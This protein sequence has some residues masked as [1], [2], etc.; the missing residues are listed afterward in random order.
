MAT[1]AAALSYKHA[2]QHLPRWE[3]WLLRHK[4]I[5]EIVGGVLVVVSLVSVIWQLTYPTNTALPAM[6]LGGIEVG[7]KDRAA[8][9]ATLTDYAQQGEV[10][11]ASPSRQWQAKWQSVGVNIDAEAS[12]DVALGYE[13]W[14]RFIPFSSLIRRRQ[15]QDLQLIALVDDERLTEFASKLVAEDKQAARDATIKVQDGAVVIDDAKNGYVYDLQEVKQQV[16]AAAVST[17][18]TLRLTPQQTAYVRSGQELAQVKAQAETVLAHRPTFK[19]GNA[20]FTADAPTVGSWITFTEDPKTKALQMGFNRDQ[21]KT[22]LN[23]IDDKTK[24][25][26]GTSTVTL[27][28]GQEVSRTPAPSGQTVAADASLD[29]IQAALLGA[30][31]TPTVALNITNVPPKVTY[32]RN[33][34]QTNAGLLA[35]IKDW[36]ATHYG[37]YAVIIRELGGQNR[38]AEFNPDKQYVTASTFKLWVY[39]A[40]Q[41]RI[42]KGQ[43]SY[44]TVTDMGWTVEACLQEMIVRSTNPCA[45]SL[46]N[47][48]GWQESQNLVAAAGFSS[49]NINNFAG[50][51]KTSTIRDETNFM[52]RLYYG[53]LMGPEANDRL[54]GYLKRQIWRT[55]IPVG[56]PRGTVV[57]NKVGLYNGWVHDVG[58]IYGPK[59]TFIIGIM[60]KSGTDP[61]FAELTR[62]VYNFFLN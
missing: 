28:D 12:V 55:G 13:F 54:L 57:A 51:D 53:T 30:E 29:K 45:A 62:R 2:H 36:D 38:Y 14:E 9:V 59:S 19:V 22:Y 50:G 49:T 25:A 60:S 52:M 10:T 58:I 8:L 4:R 6:K 23:E 33:Y 16:Q 47:L 35:I 7:G 40:V 11:I 44:Q 61:A 39:Y 17:N 32:V 3:E 31:L 37:D 21:I 18:A 1:K 46:M 34:S 41:D 5:F 27:V 20:T 56:V 42:Q 48:V 43:V 26:P 15:S 24:I